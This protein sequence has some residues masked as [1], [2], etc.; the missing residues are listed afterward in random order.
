MTTNSN[1]PPRRVTMKDIAV[2]A[3]VGQSTVSFVL[4]GRADMRIS[5]ETRN[6]VIRAAK[7]L[8]YRPRTAGR[9]PSGVGQDFIGI[10]FDEVAT[11]PWAMA[12]IEGAQEAA[13]S[14]N[15]VVEVVM[16]GGDPA[17]EAAV[18]KK[19]AAERVAGV[20]Y[21]SILTRMASSLPDGLAM[22]R[23]VLLNCYE[24]EQE[25]SSIVPAE[26]RGGEIATQT[27]IDAGCKRIAFIAGEPWME[28]S[29]QRREGY[30]RAINAANSPQDAPIIVEDRYLLSG[31]RTATLDLMAGD[32]PPDAIFCATDLIAVGCYE[33]LK[34]LGLRIGPDVAVVGYDDQDFVRHLSPPLTTVLLPHREM[35]RQAVRLLLDGA[36]LAGAE[37]RVECPIVLRQSHL[38]P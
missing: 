9:P 4:N 17:Y 37:T 14:R 36:E 21:A 18:L 26:R 1:T 3:N 12:T 11:S 33:A 24:S 29:D 16:T 7:K 15:V 27:L 13:W 28:A 31:G 30:L 6:R 19:W 2:E 34:E 25:Y 35:G 23:A 8:G 5:D 20:V 32:T 22:Q 10:I 38:R